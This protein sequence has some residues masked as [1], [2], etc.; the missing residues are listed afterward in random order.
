MLMRNNSIINFKKVMITSILVLLVTCLIASSDIANTAAYYTDIETASSNSFQGWSA[1]LWTQTSQSDFQAGISNQV[2]ITTSPGD[3]ILDEG[4]SQAVVASDDF[5]SGDWTGGTGWLWAW[6][7]ENNPVITTSGLP[8]GGSYHAQMATNGSYYYIA[9]PTNMTGMTGARVQFWAKA[10]SFG[11]SD[12][13]NCTIFDGTTWNTVQT[14]N[15]GD[16]DNTYYYF[17]IDISGMDMSSEFYVTFYSELYGPGAYFYIDDVQF[18]ATPIQY[19][20]ASDDFESGGWNGGTGWLWG[21]W[22]QGDSAVTTLGGPYEGSYHLRLRSSTGYV[23]RALDLSGKTSV[24]LQFWAKADSFEAG[25]TATCNIYDG[26]AWDTVHTWVDG[27]DDNIYRFYD[28][29]LSGYNMY[30]QFY[31]TFEANMSGTGDYFYVDNIVITQP[32]EYYTLG[33]LA[34]QVLDTGV[35]GT[36]WNM[37]IWDETLMSNTDITF[38]VRA[39]DTPFNAGDAT[40]FWTL[41]GGTSPVITG[42][43]AG[44][45]KQ[46]RVTLTTSNTANTPTLHE[47]R[48][49]YY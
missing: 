49:Y 24:H 5:E 26:V 45:Y 15:D 3:L 22:Y 41:V 23:D 16:D 7:T 33:T 38:A 42:L 2:D 44:R 20:I 13:V 36:V 27:N 46:W 48:L 17:D 39:S 34:S 25:E 8:H 30:N 35:P 29:D 40:P 32:N 47:V 18:V 1:S 11:V 12:F 21:W 10:N 19:G 6:Y 9:R 37:L 28:V 4:L 31:I 14:W 43:P